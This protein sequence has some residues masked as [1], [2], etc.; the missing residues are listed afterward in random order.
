MANIIEKIAEAIAP[1]PKFR[2]GTESGSF[3]IAQKSIPAIKDKLGDD[4]ETWL[5]IRRSIIKCNADKSNFSEWKARQKHDEQVREHSKLAADGHDL[6]EKVSRGRGREGWAQDFASRRESL[7]RTIAALAAKND[8]LEKKIVEV[9]LAT[10]HEEIAAATIAEGKL[11]VKFGFQY[12]EG[13]VVR[14][15]RGLD[16]YL[17]NRG[18]ILVFD[19]IT[20]K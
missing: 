18:A 20:N 16:N 5:Q 6:S 13:D 11:A 15:M 7:D 8:P 9:L 14:Q 3:Y 4:F 2:T 19:I 12:A 1:R 17:T 10:L